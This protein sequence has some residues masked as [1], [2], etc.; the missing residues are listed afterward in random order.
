M[1]A[2]GLIRMSAFG[3]ALLLALS[4]ASP[5]VADD[6]DCAQGEV[7]FV[8]GGVEQRLSLRIH[9]RGAEVGAVLFRITDLPAM[10]GVFAVYPEPRG[11]RNLQN[12][13]VLVADMMSF[14]SEGQTIALLRDETGVAVDQMTAPDGM[15]Y[16]A[17]L[18][19]GTIDAAGFDMTTVVTG[20]TCSD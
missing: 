20:W 4:A 10:G 3:P 1:I 2:S 15:L 7:T 14:G 13:D 11:S 6:T 5:T 19:G 17:Y 9:E 16:A 12:S 18:A 8:T